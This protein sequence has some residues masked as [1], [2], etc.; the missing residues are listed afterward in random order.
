[1]RA[2]RWVLTA[3][4][5]CASVRARIPAA[6]AGAAQSFAGAS[7][8]ARRSR[9]HYRERRNRS[10]RSPASPIRLEIHRPARTASPGPD[11]GQFGDGVKIEHDPRPAGLFPILQG[12]SKFLLRAAAATTR[13]SAEA[14]GHDPQVDVVGRSLLIDNALRPRADPGRHVI[15]PAEKLQ[16]EITGLT[17]SVVD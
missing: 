15:L 9:W 5:S 2:Q 10:Q 17:V 13:R 14:G 12:V 6:A 4:I 11:C 1:M 3:P 8:L 16:A 7:R